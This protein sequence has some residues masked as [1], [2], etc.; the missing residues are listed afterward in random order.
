[1]YPSSDIKLTL[2]PTLA[3]N[4]LPST[5]KVEFTLTNARPWGLQEILAKFNTG[6]LRTV[7]IQKDYLELD[8]Q[9]P[10]GVYFNELEN[11]SSTANSTGQSST[12]QGANTSKIPQTKE[13][14]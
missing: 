3:F 11:S 9:Q 2:G 10:G 6:H 1:M 12:S 4:D 14:A 8:N 7:N 5:I 13:N